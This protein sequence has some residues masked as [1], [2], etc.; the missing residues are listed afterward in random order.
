[1][2]RWIQV[3]ERI[4]RYITAHLEPEVE[5]LQALHRETAT[6]AQANMQISHEQARFMS[7]LLQAMGARRTIEIGVFTGYSTLMTA[8]ALPNDGYVLA[9][10]ISEEWTK[11]AR[12]YWTKA[13]VAQKIDL[14]L[15]PAQDTLQRVLAQGGAGTF[16]F[17]FI[18]ADKTGYDNYYELALQLLRP[19][20][21]IAL[22][23]CLWGGAVLNGDDRDADTVAIR[24]LNDKIGLDERVH[25]SLLP[26]GD[27]IHLVY[28]RQGACV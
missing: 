5:V 25:S 18:D 4:N 6:L 3:D 19:G 17:V 14:R 22:D 16:D 21:V 20:G 7:L 8:L 23:N 13:G 27:G 11:I 26:V 28:K 9:C 1:M 12:R 15:A 24:A 10:D 2:A